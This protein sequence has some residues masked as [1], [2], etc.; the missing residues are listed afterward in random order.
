[1]APDSQPKAESRVRNLR[2]K[3][4]KLQRKAE[5]E[6]ELSQL[7]GATW[8]LELS[9]PAQCGVT[10]EAV[11]ALLASLPA[12]PAT[13]RSG[14]SERGGEDGC[15]R[16]EEPAL[17]AEKAEPGACRSPWKACAPPPGRRLASGL[18]EDDPVAV[19]DMAARP[20]PAREEAEILADVQPFTPASRASPRL[21]KLVRATSE[22]SMEA[23]K[24]DVLE[25]VSRR[26]KW[27]LTLLVRPE[28]AA[29]EDAGHDPWEGLLG[30][31]AYKLKPQVQSISIAKLAVVPERRGRGH[32]HR[33]VQWCISLAKKSRDLVY[34]S[35]TSLPQAVRFYTRAGF[36]HI[37][38][39]LSKVDPIT[40][41]DMEYVEGQVYMEYRCKRCGTR[42][43]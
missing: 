31:I 10:D 20:R 25:G 21:R 16:H 14:H 33:L 12:D 8:C 27:K 15:L 2:K 28:N 30:F 35:L 42:K 36:R 3:R 40:E 43:R 37:D 39:D 41:D 26:G 24:T 11:G 19:E 7:L 23:F 18:W 38:V 1:M 29:T 22:L 32:G 4:T 34:L 13:P 9:P 5:L 17:A 6:A